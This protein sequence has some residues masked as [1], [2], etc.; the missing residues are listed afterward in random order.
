M[1]KTVMVLGVCLAV[2]F[3]AVGIVGLVSWTV[4]GVLA[5]VSIAIAG[6]LFD[7]LS[8]KGEKPTPIEAGIVRQKPPEEL[9]TVI[10]KAPIIGEDEHIV[11][12]I[13][14][15]EGETLRGEVSADGPV[16]VFLVTRR[17]LTK[18]EN[19]EDFWYEDGDEK[20]ARTTIDFKAPR[21]GEWFLVVDN[22]GEESVKADIKAHIE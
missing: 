5:P 4:V 13:Q 18:F 7:Y 9:E 20:V 10:D 14:L 19:E 2:F 17:N 3:I 16:N 15:K 11:Y 22:A 21:D 8:K 12:P 6:L 1:Q